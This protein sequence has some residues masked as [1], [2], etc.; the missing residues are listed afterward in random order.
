MKD[1]VKVTCVKNGPARIE[2]QFVLIK[3][4][5]EEQE[6]D[7]RVSLCR[8][9]MSDIM[10]LCDGQHKNCVPMHDDRESNQ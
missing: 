1:K 8:C 9:G 4:N 5:G 2:G 6:I 10:P 3:P 7:G